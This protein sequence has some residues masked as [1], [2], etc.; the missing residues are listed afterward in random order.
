MFRF[1]FIWKSFLLLMR[2]ICL[3]FLS[4]WLS[5]Y[6]RICISFVGLME[7]QKQLPFWG[8]FQAY[9]TS[10]YLII[11]W[12]CFSI[13]EQSLQNPHL[14][15]K[16]L[17]LLSLTSCQ[18]IFCF[19]QLILRTTRCFVSDYKTFLWREQ[20]RIE[21]FWFFLCDCLIAISIWIDYILASN[22]ASKIF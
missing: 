13:N 10:S 2:K 6:K 1:N 16:L 11:I 9:G 15:T 19:V 22:L 5:V 3:D 21:S 17:I 7:W 12:E 20:K 8:V 4:S 14:L 18:I